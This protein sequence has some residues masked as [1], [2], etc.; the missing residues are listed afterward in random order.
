[1]IRNFENDLEVAMAEVTALAAPNIAPTVDTCYDLRAT[2]IRHQR[3]AFWAASTAYNFGDVVMPVL[4]NGHRYIVILPGT[5]GTE[6]PDWSQSMW[7][8]RTDG[9]TAPDG[10]VL[11]W[12]EDGPDFTNIFDIEW[13]IYDVWMHKAGQAS[14]Q[15]DTTLAGGASAGTFTVNCSQMFNH[16]VTMAQR[17][18]PVRF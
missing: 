5:S 17:Y 10:S 13:A 15:V 8:Q 6:E 16:C 1:M 2:I 4:P 11:T 9:I 7:S 3:C 14:A 12:R 18:A